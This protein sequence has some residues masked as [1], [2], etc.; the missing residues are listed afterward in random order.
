MKKNIL[1]IFDQQS[2]PQKILNSPRLDQSR[3]LVTPLTADEEKISQVEQTLRSAAHL[4][5]RTIPFVANFNRKGYE[6]K[7][8]FVKFI[9]DFS[10]RNCGG[11]ENLKEY[12]KFPFS[13][14][15]TWWFS[16]IA[17]KNTLKTDSFHT[18]VILLTLKDLF[19]DY[20]CR[21]VW[22][23]I[24]DFELAAAIKDNAGCLK[25]FCRNLSKGKGKSEL[26]GIF[27]ALT[28]ALKYFL[29]F[30]GRSIFTKCYMFGL[31]GRKEA[32]KKCKY[33]LVTYFPNFDE[34]QL[35]QGRFVNKYYGPLQRAIEQ[36]YRQGFAWLAITVANDKYSWSESRALGRRI[37]ESGNQFIFSEEWLGAFD[38]LK[39]SLLFV[40]FSI[41]YFLRIPW[42]LKNF[43]YPEG[44]LNIWRLFKGDWHNSFCGYSLIEGLLYYQIFR[45]VSK[46][47]AQRA[48][49]IYFAE[50][51][52]WE[53]ALN[54]ALGMN[55]KIKTVGIQHTIVPLMLLGYFHDR[56]ELDDGDYIQTLPRPNY[57]ACAGE[58]TA[59]LFRDTGW[60]KD[61]VFSWGALRFQHFQHHLKHTV[62]WEKRKNRVVIAL[63]ILPEESKEI[64]LYVHQAFKAAAGFEIFI[65]SHP[66][67][68]IEELTHRLGLEFNQPTFTICSIPLEEL[69]P[70]AKAVIVTVSSASLAAIA[71]GCPVI[72]PR[73]PGIIDMNPLSGLSQLPIYV[74]SP[75]QMRD[76]VEKILRKKEFPL[77]ISQCR[78]FIFNYCNL[79][80]S[81]DDFLRKLEQLEEAS[82]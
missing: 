5:F 29:V 69:L 46:H 37:N 12:F 56:A 78:D 58:T 65:K 13:N 40:Y 79:L 60:K 15:S 82:R 11:G 21:E 44:G 9:A 70:D 34:L 80:D 74:E 71:C 17:E 14:F 19:R 63:S 68:P 32:L 73:L 72:I 23:D 64:L 51:H 42:L 75:R 48:N 7:D 53:K 50:M 10:R 2:I 38:W 33:L 30:L 16:L 1:Y 52:C 81:D 67:L 26:E 61:R 36:K 35:K 59:K 20:D 76:V 47:L 66:N 54:I 39:V 6:T 41:K 4:E 43:I 18:L 22:I 55:G 31:S 27:T 77:S 24:A 28:F 49:V 62:S 57:L 45:N 8:G 25:I 3:I